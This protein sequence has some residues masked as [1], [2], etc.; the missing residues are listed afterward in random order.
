MTKEERKQR[1]E[2]ETKKAASLL[3]GICCGIAAFVV[4]MVLVLAFVLNSDKPVEKPNTEATVTTETETETEVVPTE[5]E[6]PE[7]V[8]DEATQQAIAVVSGM[9]LE[10]KVAQMFFI[11]PDALTGVNGATVMGN[12]TKAAYEKYPVG[13]LIYTSKNLKTTEQTKE[14]L[15]KMEAFAE[16]KTGLPI[17]LGIDEE[18]GSHNRVASISGFGISGLS[19]TSEIGATGD[20]SKAYEMSAKIGNYLYDLGFNTNF[21]PVADVLTNEENDYLANRTFG[22]DT[23]NVSNMVLSSLQGLDENNVNGVVKYFPGYGSI[24]EDPH[25][26]IISTNKSLEELMAVE[27]VPFQNAINGGADFMMVG[28]VTVPNITGTTLPSSMSDYMI[29]EVLRNQ[30]GFEGVVI[31]DAMNMKAI[32]N[33]YESAEAAILAINAGADMI[34]MPNDFVEAYEGVLEA[35]NNGQISEET[36]NAAVVRIVKA[37]R[38]M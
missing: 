30:M 13:G 11:T 19:K 1:R 24:A 29:K 16:E 33:S 10:Q 7:P 28:H 15:S 22:S 17:F 23:G 3:M 20:S 12:S 18:S 9:T 14:M 31:T 26:G 35:V 2:Q 38:A 6:E 25:D 5:T 32:T 36:I 34:L 8:I 4:L 27:L 37:K 21:A